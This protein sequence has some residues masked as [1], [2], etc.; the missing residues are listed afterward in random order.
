MGEKRYG[1]IGLLGLPAILLLSLTGCRYKEPAESPPDQA[2]ARLMSTVYT[3]DPNAAPQ[4]LSGFY[5]VEDYSWRWTGQRFSVV[6]RPPEGAGRA[7]NLV[8]QLAVPDVVIQKLHSITLS[9]AVRGAQ[10]DPETYTKPGDYKYT[11]AI[12]RKLLA[13]EES[14]IDFQLDKVM[15]PAG[16]D[17]RQ[18]GIVVTSIGLEPQ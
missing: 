17:V 5:Q 18:L 3:A 1:S 15:P 2:A 9:A 16:Q 13:S 12:A 14:R 4:L 6:L 7:A 11:R 10:L 8:V